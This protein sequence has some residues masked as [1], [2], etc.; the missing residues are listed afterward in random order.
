MKAVELKSRQISSNFLDNFHE[1]LVFVGQSSEY[2]EE[3][4]NITNK[5][6]FIDALIFISLQ[7]LQKQKMEIF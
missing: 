2:S 6:V 3:F 4:E 5:S 1:K 7:H